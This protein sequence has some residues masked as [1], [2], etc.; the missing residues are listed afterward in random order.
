MVWYVLTPII[1]FQE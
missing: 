1:I